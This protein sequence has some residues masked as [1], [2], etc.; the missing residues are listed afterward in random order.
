M[1]S[2]LIAKFVGA[3]LSVGIAG[4]GSA[5]G[6]GICANRASEALTRQPAA[7]TEIVRSMLLAQAV[8]ETSGIFGLMVAVILLFVDTP[9]SGLIQT[10]GM[11]SAGLC[12]GI[13]ALG[14]GLGS[15]MA[16]GTACSS[17][18]RQPRLSNIITLNMLVGQ[19]ISQTSSIFALV[20]AMVLM[21]VGLEG[22]SISTIVALIAAGLCMGLGSFGPGLGTGITAERALWGIVQS[23]RSSEVIPR[24]M[25]LGQAVAQ[26]TA[27]YSMVISFILIFIIH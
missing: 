16:G 19:A 1:D 14:S 7:S 9:G 23:E 17:T 5:V 20:I 15:G 2:L 13:G 12:M 25:L 10:A 3:A 26:S 24:T 22:D 11:I 18:G 21:F 6:E 8:A 4:F 27:I